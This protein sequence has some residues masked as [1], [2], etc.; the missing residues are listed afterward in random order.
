MTHLIKTILV[1]EEGGA[2]VTKV[3]LYFGAK[4]ETLPVTCEIREV[5]NGYL[6]DDIP[7]G[8]KF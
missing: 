7:F 1:T 4:D 5:I 6:N 3:D 2:F 8:E